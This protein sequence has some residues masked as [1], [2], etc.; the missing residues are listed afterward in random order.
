MV[1]FPSFEFTQMARLQTAFREFYVTKR[2]GT[3]LTWQNTLGHCVLKAAFNHV[4]IGCCLAPRGYL[5]IPPAP[6]TGSV[7]I[8]INIRACT[9]STNRPGSKA[10]DK[11]AKHLSNRTLHLPHQEFNGSII[12][13]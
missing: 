12:V 3:K 1:S 2:A 8:V 6:V 4:C 11:C 13:T 5:S 9:I 10:N 7:R